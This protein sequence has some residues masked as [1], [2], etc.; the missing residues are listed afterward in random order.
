MAKEGWTKR[1]ILIVIIIAL[2]AFAVG[3]IPNVIKNSYK[4]NYQNEEFIGEL[5]EAPGPPYDC[6]AGDHPCQLKGCYN[7]ALEDYK[8]CFKGVWLTK[9]KGITTPDEWKKCHDDEM[10]ECTSTFN[11]RL[12]MCDLMYPVK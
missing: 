11:A 8:N 10:G 12:N 7:K 1:Q 3:F 5:A 4:G 6:P 9:C 2:I